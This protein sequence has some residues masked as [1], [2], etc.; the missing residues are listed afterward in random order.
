MKRTILLILFSSLYSV[1]YGQIIK[2]TILNKNTH[3]GV[4][5]A[6]IYFNGT[7]VG[8][9]SDKNGFFKLDVSKY[10]SMPL[11]IS[12]IGYYSE[13]LTN[14]LTD[15]INI[16]Y[17]T[18]RIYELNEVVINAK[19]TP[20]AR[21]ER[22]AN[23]KVFKEEFL[24]KTMN[25][26]RCDIINEN[27]ITLNYIYHSDTLKKSYGIYVRTLD[28]LKAFS[29]K[30]ITINNKALGYKITFY[31][32][33]FEYCNYN[34]HYFNMGSCFFKED[35]AVN[36]YQ[37]KRFEVR[38]KSAYLGSRMH[39]FRALWENTLDLEGFTVK[40]SSNYRL[41][42]DRL[43]YQADSNLDTDHL[44]YFKYRGLISIAY[45]SKLPNSIIK[46]E[47]DSVCF[48]KNTVLNP[49]GVS[50]AGE[51]FRQRIGD[52]LPFGYKVK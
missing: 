34:H 48:N 4:S 44:K 28:T 8:I 30:P 1:S 10:T 3:D 36:K 47:A 27:D 50:W 5:D 38:R 43:V 52:L 7:S 32:D 16:I 25:A 33:K 35:S 40:N 2:G 23:L 6:L 19:A 22:K 37:Q 42:Y 21:R 15:K 12:S 49:L 29:S 9:Y 24:G 51:M 18:P 41:T 17:L 13:T 20:E 45:H 31:L 11:T 26:K 46:I 14:F 39:F